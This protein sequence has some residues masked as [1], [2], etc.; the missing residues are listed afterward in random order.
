MFWINA[1]SKSVAG[2]LSACAVMTVLTVSYKKHFQLEFDE[3]VQNQKYHNNSMQKLTI[4]AI[5]LR[6]T[7]NDQY[8]YYFMSLVSGRKINR[9]NWTPLP[10]PQ[11]VIDCVHRLAWSNPNGLM[12]CDRDR[13]IYPKD[14]TGDDYKNK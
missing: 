12:I 8:S 2:E 5:S 13:K 6:P 1:L 11:D 10:M 7:G 9:D 14:H 4:G 3:S